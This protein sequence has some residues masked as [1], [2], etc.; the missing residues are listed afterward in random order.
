MR[1]GLRTSK[2]AARKARDVVTA[3][4]PETLITDCR[5]TQTSADALI[6]GTFNGALTYNL[7]AA[8]AE[9]KGALSYRQLHAAT[10][11]KLKR[12]GYD[13]VPQ[14]E[15]RRTRLDQPFLSLWS[16]SDRARVAHF[17]SPERMMREL[18]KRC[19]ARTRTTHVPALT[20]GAAREVDDGRQSRSKGE[21]HHSRH[22]RQA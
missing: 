7:V 17:A 2:R 8:I 10:I 11:A 4:I 9:A 1:G 21:D 14:V 15:G 6:G 16:R 20:A 13:Q 22:S 18:T 19:R 3:D 12:G 5:D